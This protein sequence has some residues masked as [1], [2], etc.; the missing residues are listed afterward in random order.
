MIQSINWN[1]M[2]ELGLIRRINRDILHPL[3]LA[4]SRNPDTGTS[5]EILISDDGEWEYSPDILEKVD[6]TDAEIKQ[7]LTEMLASKG[8]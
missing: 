2:S 7:K 4:I 1:Q 3:G 5:E 8:Q 6:L